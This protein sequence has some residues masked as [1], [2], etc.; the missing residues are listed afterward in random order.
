M[1]IWIARIMASILPKFQNKESLLLPGK[2]T[3]IDFIKSK[4]P[5]ITG[6]IIYTPG[7]LTVSMLHFQ[8]KLKK[9]D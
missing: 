5:L 1:T 2:E 6:K 3:N 4:R 7:I 8:N 9:L